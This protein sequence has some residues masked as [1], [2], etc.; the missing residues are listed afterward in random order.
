MTDKWAGR[1]P[2]M[3]EYDSCVMEGCAEMPL[4]PAVPAC[5][6]HL[7][8]RCLMGVAIA[9]VAGERMCRICL[10]AVGLHDER[11]TIG[12]GASRG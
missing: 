5:R 11:R 9:E 3:N 10:D 1:V 12:R 7:C 8:P 6:N 4:N 2:G